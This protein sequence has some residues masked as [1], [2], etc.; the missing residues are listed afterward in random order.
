MDQL[1]NLVLEVCYPKGEK[2]VEAGKPYA[3]NLWIIRHG[4]LLVY[5][6]KRDKLYNLESGDYFGD[7]SVRGDPERISSHNAVCEENLTAWV[8]TREDIES[9]IGSIERLGESTEFARSQHEKSILFSNLT[10]HRMLGQ[11]AFGSV[12]LVTDR[13]S[14]SPYA[15]K[16]IRKRMLLDSNQEQGVMRE[17]ELLCLLQHPFILHL[18][19]SFQDENCLYLLLPLVPGGELFSVLT[20]QKRKDFGL[21][22]RMLLMV[23]RKGHSKTHCLSADFRLQ[24]NHAA[25]YGACVVEALGTFGKRWVFNLCQCLRRG[26]EKKSHPSHPA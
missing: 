13:Q 7:K 21:L 22:V 11:G 9:V 15:L 20:K 12:W 16:A 4:R 26:T 25:F 10:K 5:S 1:V 8:L 6:Q 17:K 18:V 14:N 23:A 3:M 24:N 19:A 2:L